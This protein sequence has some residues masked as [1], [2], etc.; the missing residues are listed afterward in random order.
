MLIITLLIL[1]LAG[2]PARAQ[3]LEDQA[4]C[5]EQARKVF[6][7]REFEFRKLAHAYDH[8]QSDHQSHYNT[9]L[10]KCFLLREEIRMLIANTSTS[11]SLTDAFERRT[12]ATYLQ[13]TFRRKDATTYCELMPSLQRKQDC[14][15]L[16]EF[17]AFVAP[18]MEE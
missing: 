18:Y 11:K 14:S 5:A 7:E 3:S 16:E 15:T 4:M 6:Q 12:Y 1:S 10:K 8:L 9:K 17:N 2:T 13:I